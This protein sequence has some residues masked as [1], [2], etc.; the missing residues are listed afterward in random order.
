[1]ERVSSQARQLCDRLLDGRNDVILDVVEYLQID[2]TQTAEQWKRG[3]IEDNI[4]VVLTI[5]PDWLVWKIACD[6][7]SRTL[8]VWESVNPSDRRPHLAIDARIRWLSGDLPLEDLA[9]S[10]KLVRD[11]CDPY[12]TNEVYA[13]C[14]AAREVSNPTQTATAA[15]SLAAYAAREALGEAEREWQIERIKFYLSQYS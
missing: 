15:S 9:V 13:A 6:F 10:H 4:D 5:L 2:G 8:V 12:S 7:A 11:A 14:G 1:M 3:E